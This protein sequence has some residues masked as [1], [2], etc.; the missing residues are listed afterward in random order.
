MTHVNER[1]LVGRTDELTAVM[2]W[3][4]DDAAFISITGPP[5]V[6][7]STLLGAVSAR[8]SQRSSEITRIDLTSQ[9]SGKE[10]LAS[11]L[12]SLAIP[13]SPHHP[14]PDEEMMRGLIASA[15][16]SRSGHLL[17]LDN[18]EHLL[19]EVEALH[20]TSVELGG[21]ARILVGSRRIPSGSHNIELQPFHE[22]DDA[23]EIIALFR[24]H[25]PAHALP[26]EQLDE[27]TREDLLELGRRVEGL[28]LSIA[29][30]A[31]RLSM[32]KTGQLLERLDARSSRDSTLT[33]LRAAIEWSWGL[34]SAD[35]QLACMVCAQFHDGFDFS[36][37]EELIQLAGASDGLGLL[38]NLHRHCMIVVEDEQHRFRGKMLESLRLFVLDKAS[39]HTTLARQHAEHFASKGWRTYQETRGYQW[40]EISGVLAREHANVIAANAYLTRDGIEDLETTVK[41]SL[42]LHLVHM[43][44]MNIPALKRMYDRVAPLL[45]GDAVDIPNDLQA[46]F[47]LAHSD[48]DSQ[49]WAR[50][51][52]IVH[53]KR[54][55]ALAESPIWRL[56]AMVGIAGL[57]RI[58]PHEEIRELIDQRALPLARELRAEREIIELLMTHAN[59]LSEE[60][61]KLEATARF[62]EVLERLDGKGDAF[63]RQLGRVQLHVGF[64]ARMAR[65]LDRAEEMLWSAYALFEEVGDIVSMG[66]TIRIIGWF[67]VDERHVEDSTSVLE[68]MRAL[69]DRY[70]LGWL[71]G[72]CQ[73]LWG[74]LHMGN[75]DFTRATVAFERGIIHLQVDRIMPLIAAC[76]FYNT[77]A[78]E[79]DGDL[80][81]ARECFESGY[82]LFEH[83]HAPV[84]KV[85]Y[86]AGRARFL[87]LE[88]K[89][90]EALSMLERA[91]ELVDEFEDDPFMPHI[92]DLYHCHVY[93]PAYKQAVEANK[94]RKSKKLLEEILGRLSR[95]MYH[96]EGL[97]QIPLERS[98][99]LRFGW[100]LLEKDL[101]D[102]IQRRFTLG[103][104]DP[105]AE[106][107]LLDTR[108]RAFRAPGELTWIDM[109]RRETPY[110][111]LQA[112]VD[113]RLSEPGEAIDPHTLFDE[114]WPDEAIMPDAAQNRLYVTI[115]TLRREGLKEVI[116]NNSN[117]YLL[118]PDVRL[119]EV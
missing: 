40:H 103:L 25:A 49:R 68:K 61:H 99:E 53:L 54:A 72:T 51:D 31:T 69:A 97:A 29:L 6:G 105:A 67:Y 20:E 23:E 77:M 22:V 91:Q 100:M 106:A 89:Q 96:E 7:K 101:P 94:A 35:E 119:I 82:E 112:L 34:L 18:A 4:A 74:Q 64:S 32:F 114:V 78:L 52:G 28:P 95:L 56:Q 113:H 57:F 62:E 104:E 65:Q 21:K 111:L 42:G 14:D 39:E 108:S 83:L 17:V 86:L 46:A 84:S 81:R 26:A 66:H 48:Y 92:I 45:E 33:G 11:L 115:N 70:S 107:L 50:D 79:L 30:L 73:F 80:E 109:A 2:A 55:E 90:K 43:R 116:L 98:A 36:D 27:A 59:M 85:S 12:S 13:P 16:N 75:R 76:K 24:A 110:R 118:D 1:D 19:S 38:D 87:A 60:R 102:D 10:A 9:R 15:I 88:G 3:L 44:R 58:A 5:G 41:A 93:L 71:K 37:A 117:G 8:W 63:K 47:W